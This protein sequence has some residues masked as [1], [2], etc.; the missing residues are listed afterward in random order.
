MIGKCVAIT[1]EHAVNHRLLGE[2]RG[3]ALAQRRC[4]LR[5]ALRI[6]ECGRDR[7]RHGLGVA[8]REQGR[9]FGPKISGMPPT[10]AAIMG[11]PAAPASIT[12]YGMES[13]REG[14]TSSRPLE[15]P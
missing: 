7:F 1:R 12:T 6:V 2:M 11:M 8:R 10:R 14:T 5:G 9:A 3:D 4:A 13:P 15:K